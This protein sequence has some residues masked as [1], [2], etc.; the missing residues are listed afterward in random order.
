[1]ENQK[2]SYPTDR[3][4]DLRG[5]KGRGMKYQFQNI[6]TKKGKLAFPLDAVEEVQRL[7][8]IA[9]SY[10]G[11]GSKGLSFSGI[12]ALTNFAIDELTLGAQ[13]NADWFKKSIEDGLI[14]DTEKMRAWA[15]PDGYIKF[16]GCASVLIDWLGRNNGPDWDRARRI[17]S[18]ISV[19][20]VLSAYAL[21]ELDQAI[22]AQIRSDLKEAMT[23]MAVA[24]NALNSAGFY[25]GWDAGENFANETRKEH[26]RSGG[27]KRNEPYAKLKAWALDQYN[28]GS[29][30]SRYKASFDIAPDAIKKAKDLGSSLSVQR[31]QQTIY[32]WLLNGEKNVDVT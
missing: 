28:N 17:S 24:A 7:I 27:I 20:Q 11:L 19:S 5:E 30:P 4:S 12:S 31:A 32:E 8:V 10:C 29:Y 2:N 3:V 6:S 22:S 15:T 23:H 14:R 1:M 13:H 25:Y 16:E 9:H 21:S 18:E 26:A